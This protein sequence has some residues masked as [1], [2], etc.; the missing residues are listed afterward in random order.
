MLESL[1]TEE[2][3]W[4]KW[5]AGAAFK[6]TCK[7]VELITEVGKHR[8][9]NQ[10][11]TKLKTDK[12]KTGKKSKIKYKSWHK[13]FFKS[14]QGSEG[15]TRASFKPAA[16]YLCYWISCLFFHYVLNFIIVTRFVRRA[17]LRQ[18]LKTDVRNRTYSVLPMVRWHCC[19][20]DKGF[21]VNLCRW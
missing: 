2:T 3:R 5:R 10:H 4:Q 8:E 12:N 6:Y 13:A 15:M 1:H 19:H 20:I 11:V 9:P 16:L 17:N 14:T 7:Q 21:F 18:L